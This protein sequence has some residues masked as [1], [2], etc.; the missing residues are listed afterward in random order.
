MTNE[1]GNELITSFL[2]LFIV[3]KTQDSH[4][5]YLSNSIQC[6]YMNDTYHSLIN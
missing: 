4:I 5:L 1:V 3:K 2:F 6:Y